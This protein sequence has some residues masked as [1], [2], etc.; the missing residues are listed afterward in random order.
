[1]SIELLALIRGA[2]IPTA[3]RIIAG[4][5]VGVKKLG[6]LF[7]RETGK[8]F[9]K[10]APKVGMKGFIKGAKA[11]KGLTAGVLGI[12][13]IAMD[14]AIQSDLDKTVFGFLPGSGLIEVI[15]ASLNWGLSLIGV[16]SNF[17]NARFGF[18]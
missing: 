13:D 15:A 18:F 6:G 1:M 2:S 7:L 9:I 4:S 12:A 17:L 5:A 8:Q 11:I 14:L 10:K 3:G 16:R